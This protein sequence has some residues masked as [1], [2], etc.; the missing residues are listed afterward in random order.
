LIEDIFLAGVSTR[1]VG[2]AISKLLETKVSHGTVSNITRRLDARVKVFHNEPI[3]DE[4]Q[5]LFCDGL[6]I[7][8][9]Y[10]GRYHNRRVLVVYGITLFGRRKLLAFLQAKGESQSSWEA[11]I[12][13]AHAR[14][15]KGENL[16]L[17]IQD[18]SPGL[19]AA[20]EL[21]YPRVPIQRCWV[22]KM[23]NVS[24]CLK[25][26]HHDSCIKGARRIY[27]ARSKHLAMA[28]FK[29]WKKMWAKKAPKAVH[30]IEKDLDSLLNF[31][32]CPKKH[33]VRI[34]TTNAIERSF[35]EVRR[36]T[37][38]FSCFS[39]LKSTE[40]IIFAIFAYW[41]N[42]WKGSPVKHFTQFC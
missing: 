40:R 16:K 22:H 35:R 13:S 9:R 8:V 5:Y 42:K 17:I 2:E 19:K 26:A 36:R 34:R 38:V 23:R 33:W 39:N 14:G 24:N 7:K 6:N 37:R 4:Y 31:F 15:L 18:G 21:V 30:C 1:R 28:E 12:N 41:N 10:N 25:A 27:K 11:V 29:N 3:L 32:D 20:L